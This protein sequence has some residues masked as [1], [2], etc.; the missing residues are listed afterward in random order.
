MAARTEADRAAGEARRYER[1]LS[2]RREFLARF[3]HDRLSLA[4]LV[5][6]VVLTAAA[7][8]APLI[9]PYDPA[10][11]APAKRLQGPSLEHPLGTDQL[12]RDTFSR[13]LL[14]ARWS[15]G[16][17]I[18]AALAA[19]IVGVLVGMAAGYFGG[20]VDAILMRIVD[21]FLA[22][23]TLVVALATV[24]IFGAGLKNVM[25]ALVSVTWVTYARVVRGLMLAIRERDFIYAARAIG[26]SDMRVILRHALPNIIPPV[27]VLATLET[28]RL[29]VSLA[30]L[31]FLGLGVQPPTPEWGTM[32]NQA[33]PFVFGA[34]HLML[35]PGAAITLTVLGFNLIGDGL[36]DLLDPR[37]AFQR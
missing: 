23:P 29:I 3:L 24:G 1:I 25:I 35:F 17:A 31:G 2:G 37:L 20:L 32:L 18:A 8:F 30:A 27:I 14:G 9:A 13:I 16:S 11:Q 21:V 28:G 22:L 12:G 19:M 7:L 36:R 33:R 5:I 4:G 15:V 10:A 26:A 6:V 34:P